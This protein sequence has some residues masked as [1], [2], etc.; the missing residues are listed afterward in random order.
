MGKYKLKL[1]K[2]GES[3][4]EATITSWLKEIGDKISVDESIVEIATDKV[5]S[6]IPSEYEGVL[7]EKKFKINDIVKVGDVIAVIESSNFDEKKVEEI[8][9]DK[10][11]YIEKLEK[12]SLLIEEQI[13]DVIEL[14]EPLISNKKEFNNTVS[15]TNRNYS[16]L[17]KNIATKEGVSFEELNDIVG[18]GIDNRVT[19]KDILS[20][21]SKIRSKNSPIK[22]LKNFENDKIIELSRMGKI[23]AEH[24]TLSKKTA[25]HVQSFVEADVTDLFKW[26][27]SIKEKFFIKQNQ[28]ITFTPIFISAVINAIKRYPLLNSSFDGNKI[29]QKKDINIGMA[30]AMENGDLIVPVIKNADHLNL[31]GLTKSVNDLSNRARKKQLTSEEVQEGTYTVTNIGGFGSLTG[32]PI[33]NQ[34]QVGIIA[35]GEIRKMA[36]VIETSKGDF[37]GIRKKIIICHSYDHRIINGAL[38]GNFVKLVSEY[39]ENWDVNVEF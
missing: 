22:G 27:E 2:M 1:P 37:I 24:M 6:D 29:T 16:P 11:V 26:R 8:K 7:I 35:F 30:T 33:I 9:I 39:L 20:Y 4:A 14:T 15:P 3:I 36:S 25:A 32:T 12:K 34:P 19:K 18:T 28:K 31:V 17:V 21:I 5:D 23:I 13:N 38:G 10:S